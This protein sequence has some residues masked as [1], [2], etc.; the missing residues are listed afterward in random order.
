V[1]TIDR[2]RRPLPRGSSIAVIGAGIV[3]TSA[4]YALVERGYKVTLY[5]RAQPGA[6]GPSWGNAGHVVGSGI[7]PLGEPGAAWSGLRMLVDPDGP[8]KIPPAYYASIAPWLWRFWQSSRGEAYERG[9]NALIELNRNAVEESEDLWSRAGIGHLSRRDPALYLYESEQSYSA[10]L[11]HW[12]K[13][14]E[15]G[16][17]CT[18]LDERDVRELEPNLAPI[19]P[20]GILSHEW[21][22]VSDPFEIVTGLFHAAQAHG[23]VHERA[24]VGSVAPQGDLVTVTANG[25]PRTYDAALITAGVWSKA[26]A[27]GLGENL[28]VEAERGYN[29][30][31]PSKAGLINRPLVLADRG[32]VATPLSPGLR[33]GGWTELGGISLPPNPSRWKRMREISDAVLPALE[34]GAANEWMGHRPSVPDSV[35]VISRSSKLPGVFYAVG[36]GHYGLSQSAKT[37]R[38]I[39]EIIADAADARYAAHSIGRF[40]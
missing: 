26:L 9:V 28:P 25:G 39:T 3:G 14:A 10:S 33:L 40:N 29:L 24:T 22:I 23:V 6:T 11:S 38:M 35:P 13:R 17:Q 5:D 2:G 12:D 30:T 1:S 34:G 37:A 4:A 32:V 31:Y 21:A 16:L 20:R 18:H 7:F 15:V 36:H 8:L 27:K 19:F